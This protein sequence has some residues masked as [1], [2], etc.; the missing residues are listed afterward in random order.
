MV[1]FGSVIGLLVGC[2]GGLVGVVVCGLFSV[3][4]VWCGLMMDR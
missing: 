2:V 3:C 1:G 4:C